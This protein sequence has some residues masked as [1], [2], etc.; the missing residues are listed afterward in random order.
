MMVM[1]V[2]CGKAEFADVDNSVVRGVGRASDRF[3]ESDVD[4]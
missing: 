2:I 1:D 3:G 4:A